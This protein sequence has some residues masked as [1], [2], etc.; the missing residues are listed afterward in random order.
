[1]IQALQY[2][3]KALT[4]QLAKLGADHLKVATTYNNIAN[5]YQIQD[6]NEEAKLFVI[7]MCAKDSSLEGFQ[8][9]LS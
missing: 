1:M 9:H 4:I 3:E 7:A 6:K 5:V 8:G 2:Y